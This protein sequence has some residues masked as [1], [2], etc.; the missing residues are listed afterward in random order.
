MTDYWVR[1]NQLASEPCGDANQRGSWKIRSGIYYGCIYLPHQP[2][3]RNS[4]GE[5]RATGEDGLANVG[6]GDSRP[7]LS[8]IQT[9]TILSGSAERSYRHDDPGVCQLCPE[10]ALGGKASEYRADLARRRDLYRDDRLVSG[11]RERQPHQ[12]GHQHRLRH[13]RPHHPGAGPVL[14][15]QSVPRRPPRC[16]LRQGPHARVAHRALLCG[17]PPKPVADPRSRGRHGGRVYLPAHL[18]RVRHG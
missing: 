9:G 4:L 12:P 7:W 17:Q 5:R 6:K 14:Q 3:N 18:H 8:R 16:R 2:L 11:E 10:R 1:R 15:H 13:R